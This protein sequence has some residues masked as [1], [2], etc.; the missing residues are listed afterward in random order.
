MRRAGGPASTGSSTRS[1]STCPA[2]AG[3]SAPTSCA[4]SP[5]RTLT[6]TDR[7]R[8]HAGIA[9]W[10]EANLVAADADDSVVDRI[11]YHYG[12]AASLAQE[13]GLAASLPPDLTDGRCSWLGEAGRRAKAAEVHVLAARLFSQALDLAGSEPTPQRLEFLLGRADARWGLFELDAAPLDVDEA[14]AWPTTSATPRS[15]A[16]ARSRGRDRAAPRR[17]RAGRSP[18]SRRPSRLSGALGD[19][20]GE[21]E[22]LRHLGMTR[23]SSGRTATP[24]STQEALTTF[25]ELGDR[26]GE[27]WALQ[28]LA[29][30]SYLSG[31][32]AE[33]EVRIDEAAATFTE[34][35]DT[36][37][38]L[39]QRP[40]R[41]HPLPSR[42][43]GRGRAGG[44]AD[45]ARR[46]RAGRPL[47]RGHDVAAHRAGAAVVGP[48]PGRGERADEAHSL[49][50]RIGDT[51][52]QAQAEATSGRALVASG[53]SARACAC[54]R[55]WSA[56]APTQFLAGEAMGGLALAA[57]AL[58]VGDVDT[59]SAQLAVIEAID[60]DVGEISGDERAAHRVD[61]PAT[62]RGGSS[63]RRPTGVARGRRRRGPPADG[64]RR[65]VPGPGGHG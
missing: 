30:I 13:L 62:G 28:N 56:P 31:R 52:G 3:R 58:H 38:W 57:T 51:P 17:A 60:P 50:A 1:S 9:V 45:P 22:A 14:I 54:S 46:P 21:A 37:G 35:G 65:A 27:A 55:R 11:A 63:C 61:P 43:P 10:I 34:I 41:L 47:R 33:A 39:G 16:G 44:R 64:A 2:L 5:T 7:A 8:R 26:R 4:R 23:S 25:R 15:G 19:R 36:A 48:H 29:W 18:P 53:R 12:P 6:K 24:S 20:R 42:P 32:I 40:A 59:A 49:F